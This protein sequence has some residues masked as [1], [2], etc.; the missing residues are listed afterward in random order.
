MVADDLSQ[1]LFKLLLLGFGL[2]CIGIV[3]IIIAN[4]S[5]G[6][7]TNFGGVIVTGPIPI[8]FGI[9]ENAWVVALFASILTIVC[10][11]LFFLQ[12]RR[13]RDNS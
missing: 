9:G 8:I 4:L 3:M 5:S 13:K 1:F 2:I 6:T 7:L 12:K 10:L 11:L